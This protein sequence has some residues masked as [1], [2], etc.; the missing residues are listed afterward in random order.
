MSLT[1]EQVL[2]LI[3][4]SK[5]DRAIIV[6][7]EVR[8][9]ANL[10]LWALDEKAREAAYDRR[11][12]ENNAAAA[13]RDVENQRA[14]D[15]RTDRYVRSENAAAILAA[16]MRNL[17]QVSIASGLTHDDMA[18]HREELYAAMVSDSVKLADAL[19]AELGKTGGGGK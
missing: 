9:L 16:M 2:E 17:Q 8:Q 3:E 6:G 7:S 12:A 11:N 14:A 10:A 19:R 1:T 18:A 4:R 13:A 15:E 5:D